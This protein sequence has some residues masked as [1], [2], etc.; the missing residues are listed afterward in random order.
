MKRFL[1]RTITLF[2]FSFYLACP[3]YAANTYT[4]D[5]MHSYVIWHIDHF[6]FSSPSGKWMVNGTL[7]LD[8]AKP[9][10]SKV[11]VTI[12][13]GDVI[14]GIPKLDAHLKGKDFFDVSQFPTARFVSDKV[15]M[16]GKKT[17]KVFG[18]LV[19]HGVSKP[20]VLKVGLNKI[21]ISPI[22][23]KKTVGFTASTK[24]K[25]SDFGVKAYLPGLGDDVK[26]DIEA[27]G[28]L[29]QS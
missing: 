11:N 28:K 29:V 9:Q 23:N 16:T 25:R 14:T 1:L 24:I 5:S 27:E 22:D 15:V 20:V 10:N 21:G 3:A 17:A 12:Q 26:L 2:T 13:V 18:T 7:V 8:D 19:L 4:L 6:G